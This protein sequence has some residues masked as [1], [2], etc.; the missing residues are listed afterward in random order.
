MI[1]GKT[2]NEKCVLFWTRLSAQ[3]KGLVD[4][5]VEKVI[6]CYKGRSA[7][8]KGSIGYKVNPFVKTLF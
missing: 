6:T 7:S 1:D 5:L 2:D 8:G 4:L 3:A